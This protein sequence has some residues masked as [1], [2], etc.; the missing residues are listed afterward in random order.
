MKKNSD[1]TIVA[2]PRTG[3]LETEVIGGGGR[4]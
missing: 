4:T 1:T 2:M 3:E